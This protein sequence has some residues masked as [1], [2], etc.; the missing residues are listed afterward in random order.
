M[1]ATPG[2]AHE[3]DVAREDARWASVA[4][5][6]DGFVRTAVTAALAQAGGPCEVAIVLADDA[7]VHD[8][9]RT[10]RGQDK[11]TNVLSFPSPE[12]PPGTGPRHLGDVV[13]A[14]ETMLRESA[15]QGTPLRH[16][17]AHLL[18]HGTLHLLGHDHETGA[19]DAAAMEGLETAILRGLSIPDPYADA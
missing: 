1:T 7:T 19:D 8:L 13:L 10:W 18:V 2:T 12:T 14:Y 9:N 3:I 11:P 15:E 17:L 4:D 16:H 6:L 5:D